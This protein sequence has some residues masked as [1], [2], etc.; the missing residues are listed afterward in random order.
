LYRVAG[1]SVLALSVLL[2]LAVAKASLNIRR[3]MLVAHVVAF[4][5]LVVM[6]VVVFSVSVWF[7]A[8][9]GRTDALAGFSFHQF[10]SEEKLLVAG[11]VV[12]LV[13]ALSW[14]LGRIVSAIV[15]PRGY[16]QVFATRQVR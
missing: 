3:S 14:S 10:Y 13:G 7:D 16:A 11:L 5:S 2:P 12:V 8:N 4:S 9:E 6:A 1:A 15:R